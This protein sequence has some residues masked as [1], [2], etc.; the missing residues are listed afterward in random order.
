MVATDCGHGGLRGSWSR[1]QDVAA[2]TRKMCPGLLP[3]MSGAS[4]PDKVLPSMVVGASDK[5]ASRSPGS[6][7]CI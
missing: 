3:T 2:D 4:S 1:Y 7:D 5:C 6:W